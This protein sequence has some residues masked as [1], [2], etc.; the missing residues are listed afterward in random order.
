MADEPTNVNLLP[1]K[2][3][4][5][6]SLKSE[7]RAIRDASH[8]HDI[9]VG[10]FKDNDERV[11]EAAKIRAKADGIEPPLS[12]KK[13][14]E[15]GKS[16]KRNFSTGFLGSVIERVIPRLVM[17]VK[18]SRYLT[19]SKLPNTY[20]KAVEKTEAF[21]QIVTDAIRNWAGWNFFL[22]NLADN[23]VKMG[24]AFVTYED[25]T[26]W[27]PSVYRLDDLAIPNGTKQG[28][29]PEYFGIRWSYSVSEMF[30]FI[31][32]K[33]TAE[34]A[35]WNIEN[36]VDA[37]NKARPLKEDQEEI[38][39]EAAIKYQ[40]LELELVK[41]DSFTQDWDSISVEIIYAKEH[42][43]KV[44]CW[45]INKDEPSKEFFVAEDMYAD[46]GL[47]FQSVCYDIGNGTVYGSMGVGQK[48]YDLSVCIEKARNTA[49]D[50]LANRGKF[51]VVV[52]DKS[53]LNE[54]ET[55]ITDDFI[56][57]AGAEL[58]NHKAALA[59][60]SDA[61]MALDRYTRG[62]AEEKV[63]AFQPESL[64]T[65]KTATQSRIDALKEA[66][67][68]D[69]KLDFWLTYIGHIIHMIQRRLMSPDT[70]DPVAQVA[71]ER[72]LVVMN[73]EELQLLANQPPAQTGIDWTDSRQQQQAS[74]LASKLG[75]P[76]WDQD[77]LERTIA[78][79]LIGAE[80]TSSGL[81]PKNDQTQTIE[82]TRQQQDES[83]TMSAQGLSVL[84]SPR[85]NHLVHMQAIS[86]QQ[87]PQS[88]N[89]TGMLFALLQ[90][91]NVQGAQAMLEHYQQHMGYAEQQEK[92]GEYQNVAKKFVADAG[93]AL[94]A[95]QQ[96]LA[97]PARLPT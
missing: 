95:A 14:S 1:D 82:A 83:F 70:D 54:I 6:I 84:V 7:K 73:E 56:Y 97:A 46:M 35:G 36:V 57:I 66:E 59:D 20:D 90:E 47:A 71:R 55:T 88:G 38:P 51:F 67:T 29:P 96:M 30:K 45:M 26:E 68:S 61:F 13:L 11:T 77:F 72:C 2:P 69:A 39:A 49:F 43:G 18:A 76:A 21:R 34:D 60:N 78:S 8:V 85:D 25:A 31:A 52:A 93:R 62:L 24:K 42:D 19:S 48:L 79:M 9:V 58:S 23:N 4:L 63:G 32:D 64:A 37:I 50:Q 65:D 12:A 44:T 53:Q 75:N 3:E 16:H 87:E 28:E 10:L 80:M 89:W 81:L 5:D 86:G 15:E 33:E 94:Q 27:R 40:D 74:Y 17:R 22:Y 91:Q 41:A 92:L